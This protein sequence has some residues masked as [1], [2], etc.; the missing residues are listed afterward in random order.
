MQTGP[1]CDCVDS[2]FVCC[3]GQFH[4][5]FSCEGKVEPGSTPLS[6][7]QRTGAGGHAS[8]LED[9]CPSASLLTPLALDLRSQVSPC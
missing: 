2:D 7:P 1:G 9:S 5:H 6:P 8:P 3:C 4:D